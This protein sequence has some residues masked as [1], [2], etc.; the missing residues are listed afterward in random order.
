MR[1]VDRD[2]H[3][4]RAIP[5]TSGD[6]M[7][8]GRDHDDR[9]RF[10]APGAGLPDT[11]PARRLSGARRAS[12]PRPGWY[13]YRVT[14]SAE[15]PS[16]AVEVAFTIERP[17]TSAAEIPAGNPAGDGPGPPGPTGPTGPRSRV[18]A[19]E[20]GA[21]PGSG[22]PRSVPPQSG[23]TGLWYPSGPEPG[24][25]PE[26]GAAEALLLLRAPGRMRWLETIGGA[27][28]EAIAEVE[29]LAGVR[30]AAVAGELLAVGGGWRGPR[31][32]IGPA[33]PG[34]TPV[35]AEVVLAHLRIAGSRGLPAPLRRRRP[36]AGT[37]E[38]A[39]RAGAGSVLTCDGPDGRSAQ[40]VVA[41]RGRGNAAAI[42]PPPG[43]ALVLRAW[44]ASQRWG[45]AC[46]LVL[47]AAAAAGLGREAGRVAAMAQAEG[48]DAF[49]LAGSAT[50]HLARAGSPDLPAPED[51]AQ[52]ASRTHVA[53]RF[54]A[55]LA[56]G[57]LEGRPLVPRETWQ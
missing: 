1:P 23:V 14:G 15:L 9:Y 4:R 41:L 8:A 45:M 42:T 48:W 51:L 3:L 53:E 54:A 57:A 46:G 19:A 33:L 43:G 5:L 10:A 26:G 11:A 35:T 7:L 18:R 30:S 31:L 27:V 38:L 55:C 44:Q 17:A 20:R 6:G 56:A 22:E 49:L 12:T 2:A 52:A 28:A 47:G 40:A 36:G 25:R 24:S 13:G 32:R 16:W 37:V 34:L 39:W 29:A 50:M 21:G